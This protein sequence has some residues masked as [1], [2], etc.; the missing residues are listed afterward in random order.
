MYVFHFHAILDLMHKKFYA[1]GFLFHPD[2]EQILLQQFT[3][4]SQ[5]TAPWRI[6][7]KACLEEEDSEEVFKK[8]VFNS[9]KLKIDNVLPIYSSAQDKQYDTR[10]IVYSEVADL[11]HFSVNDNQT[12]AWFSFKAILKLQISEQEKHDIVVG[13][14]V[15]A[16]ATRRVNGEQTL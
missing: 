12:F 11:S 13:Q 14:R 4:D 2:S 16:A 7:G 6:F 3:S 5:L 1:G 10:H 15:I 9:L 8:I